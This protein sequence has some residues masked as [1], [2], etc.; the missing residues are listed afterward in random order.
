[1]SRAAIVRAAVV[2]ALV[3]GIGG[4]LARRTPKVASVPRLSDAALTEAID[5]VAAALDRDPG[6]P[7]L[8]GQL[9]NR[10]IL[11]FGRSADLGDIER[12]ETLAAEA[13]RLAP[14]KSAALARL[15]GVQ[16]MQHKFQPALA[17]ARAATLAD[18]ASG[19]A[20][21]VLLEAA[22]AAGDYPA[23]EAAVA[24]IDAGTVAGRVRRA[25]WLDNRGY[26]ATAR[27]ELRRACDE[28]DRTGAIPEVRVWC[29]VQLTNLTH[30]LAGPVEARAG[31]RRALA[32]DPENRGAREALANLDLAEGHDRAAREGFA[33]LLSPAHPD[34]YLKLAEAERRL[35]RE[36]EARRWEDRFLAA[37]D[38]PEVEA[39]FGNVLALFLAERGDAASLD[40]ARDMARREV[41]RRPTAESWDL[42]AWVHYRRGEFGAAETASDS[43]AARGGGTATMAYHRARVLGTVGRMAEAAELDRE[44]TADPT[45]LAPHVRRDLTARKEASR[46]GAA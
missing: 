35:G 19:E 33:G 1:M 32:I 8:I 2:V 26:S 6:S 41:V 30:A 44:A 42:L 24:R 38:H 20:Q 37:A 28:L 34:L 5:Y 16:L 21:G 7:M 29:L 11:R 25:L 13:L 22:V 36:N 31:Y 45:L 40:R 27:R 46:R 39:L 18:P 15:S 4:L 10:L 17:S 12:A 43:A 23:A 9:V 14:G 3:A